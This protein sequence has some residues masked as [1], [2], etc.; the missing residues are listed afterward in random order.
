M[1]KFKK[2]IYTWLITAQFKNIV[3]AVLTV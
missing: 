1:Y 2:F 3:A